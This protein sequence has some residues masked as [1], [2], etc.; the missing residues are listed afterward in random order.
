MPM[1]PIISPDEVPSSAIH[2]NSGNGTDSHLLSGRCIIV[3][4]SC[5]SALA[6]VA[7][8]IRVDQPKADINSR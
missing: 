5:C 2:T 7:L 8:L 6:F 1:H 3:F 4:H